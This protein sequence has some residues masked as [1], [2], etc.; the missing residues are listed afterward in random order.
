MAD[1][2][3]GAFAAFARTGRPA[4]VLLPPWPAYDLTRRA[5]MI[6]DEVSR[7]T[8]DPRGDER[9]IFAGVPYIQR[10]TY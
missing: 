10:G 1:V 6:F 5:T 7:V 2:V 3:S 9:R 4:T 8:D